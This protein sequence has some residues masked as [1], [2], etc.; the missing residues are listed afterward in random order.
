MKQH[1][2][3]PN[4]APKHRYLAHV[5]NANPE[6]GD[7]GEIMDVD[8]IID[9]NIH[10]DNYKPCYTASEDFSNIWRVDQLHE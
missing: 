5:L 3:T 8:T 7:V 10:G 9:H 2:S 6:I 1:T 4:H